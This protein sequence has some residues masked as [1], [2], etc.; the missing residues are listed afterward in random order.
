MTLLELD[1]RSLCG[2]DIGHSNYLDYPT[3]I[4]ICTVYPPRQKVRVILGKFGAIFRMSAPELNIVTEGSNREEVWTKFLEETRKREDSAWLVFDVG[5]TR[6]EEIEQG[7][8][9]P[10]D[11]NW[12]EMTGYIEE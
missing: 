11:E 6:R 8:N 2:T 5:P 4:D 3:D 10:E 9:A 12:S 1:S 7:L